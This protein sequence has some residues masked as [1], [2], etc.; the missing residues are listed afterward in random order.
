MARL[1]HVFAGWY[2]P[3]GTLNVGATSNEVYGDAVDG[4]GASDLTVTGGTLT[5][6]AGAGGL[7]PSYQVFYRAT[8][9]G[10][11]KAIPWAV[12]S[13]I[14]VG[15]IAA[16]SNGNQFTIARVYRGV[17]NRWDILGE[18]SAGGY[19]VLVL[20]QAGT[21]IGS[22]SSAEF[23]TGTPYNARM[24]T[25]GTTLDLFYGGSLVVSGAETNK[26][27]L[28]AANTPQLQCF[29]GSHASGTF[30][31]TFG[32]CALFSGDTT[33]D[34][35]ADNV[36][37]TQFILNND[38][39]HH[40]G[41]TSVTPALSNKDDTVDDWETGAQD[42]ATSFNQAAGVANTTYVQSYNTNTITVSR[43]PEAV[44]QYIRHRDNVSSKTET[45]SV[46]I[47]DGTNERYGAA[48][49]PDT[50][51]INFA[52]LWTLDPASAAWGQTAITA[53]QIG[54]RSVVGGTAVG[55]EVTCQYAELL[56]VANDPPSLIF[57]SPVLAI[58]HIIGR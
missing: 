42:G 12:F 17:S 36:L 51:Y 35:P 41:Y 31:I 32:P 33:A 14:N 9:G 49:D 39:P 56:E 13:A 22:T 30:A 7:A 47:C 20:N 3:S 27:A 4:G 40:T 34:R 48:G 53:L 1:C 25:N 52:Y 18:K 57:R 26:I 10:A 28:V 8:D 5:C 11:I 50:S 29:S 23:S 46:L 15:S 21:Q 2:V 6:P 24:E 19:K 43:I 54:Q 58:S 55:H 45:P 37:V 16:L 44:M 38:T